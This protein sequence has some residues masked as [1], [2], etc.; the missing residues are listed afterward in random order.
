MPFLLPVYLPADIEWLATFYLTPLI[1]PTPVAT[2]LPD[3]NNPNDTTNGFVRVEAMGGVKH[4]L[5]EYNQ[6]ILCHT[7]VPF[8]YE[9]Q[10]AQIANTVVAYMSAAQGVS[11]NG[12]YVTDSARVDMPQRQSDP[13]V[14]LLRYLALAAWTVVGQKVPGSF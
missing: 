4:S 14:N 7:Y 1:A 2:R 9:V 8:E 13:K 3:V 10:G 5:T 11:I 6:R 12:W